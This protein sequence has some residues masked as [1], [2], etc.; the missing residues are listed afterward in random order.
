[1]SGSDTSAT[2]VYED[3]GGQRRKFQLSVGAIGELE[4]RCNAGIGLILVRLSAHHFYAVDVLE[5]I[6]LG[7]VGGGL[8]P[9]EAEALMRFNVFERPLAEHIGL[10][11]RIV[12]AS[13]SGV[14]EPGKSTTE[15]TSD[16][17]APATSPSSIPPAA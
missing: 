5:P 4:R 16:P 3:L 2:A 6:R 1:M 10:A 12:Q 7:L 17:A 15:G 11:A 14:P 8:T 9:A 13:V